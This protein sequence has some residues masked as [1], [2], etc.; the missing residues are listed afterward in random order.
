MTPVV[1]VN[2]W[3]PAFAPF[4]WR[5]YA[6]ILTVVSSFMSSNSKYGVVDGFLKTRNELGRGFPS[7]AVDED[8]AS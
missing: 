2:G 4:A 1:L 3:V 7:P 6:V 5:T 8:F